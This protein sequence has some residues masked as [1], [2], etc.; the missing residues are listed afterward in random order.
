MQ[1]DDLAVVVRPRKPWEACDIGVLM[2]KRWYWPMFVASLLLSLP[3]VFVVNLG[4]LFFEEYLYLAPFVF[5]WTK[6][7]WERI[8]LQML[9]QAVFGA[10]PGPRAVVSAFPRLMGKQLIQ[11]L[12]WRRLSLSRAFN[13]PV[14]QLEGLAGSA[15]KKRIGVLRGE[16]IDPI[17]WTTLI[18]V[19]VESFLYAAIYLVLLFLI[20][21]ELSETVFN[22]WAQIDSRVFAILNGMTYY[23]IMLLVM[24]FYVATGFA[25]YLNRRAELEGWDIEIAFRKLAERD[26]ERTRRPKP[27]TGTITAALVL[28]L[29]L[30]V[31]TQP[32]EAQPGEAIQD[33]ANASQAAELMTDILAGPEFHV[34]ETVDVPD[35]DWD[36]YF[37]FDMDNWFFRWL[38]RL[39]GNDREVDYSFIEVILW[40]VI[41]LFIAMLLLR[42]GKW[43]REFG[44][45]SP[46]HKR[47]IELPTFLQQAGPE[48]LPDDVPAT[49][50]ELWQQGNKRQALALL[51]RATL[52]QLIDRHALP[53]HAGSTEGQCATLIDEHADGATANYFRSLSLSWQQ[54]AYGNM[55]VGRQQFEKLA[56][57]WRARVVEVSLT[58]GEA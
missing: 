47:E 25:L 30:S 35:I 44:S 21:V 9:S 2:A 32:T 43:I 6:P 58:G 39:F 33:L 3:F 27:K 7:L 28:G 56:D 49:A 5:W 52:R 37:S 53:I 1:L 12:F 41:G 22:L 23:L 46:R 17:R 40:T 14:M 18:G 8:H 50:H 4:L 10:L 55:P 11:T 57:N 38:E 48:V 51:Y 34:Q 29:A 42:Y 26:D 54:F 13:A 16:G 45:I 36:D 24:P 19:H 15:R 31:S 20:P